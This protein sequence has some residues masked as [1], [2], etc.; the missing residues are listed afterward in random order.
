MKKGERSLLKGIQGEAT[1]I[2]G[3][4]EGSIKT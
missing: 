2:K 3:Y 1:K 4:L